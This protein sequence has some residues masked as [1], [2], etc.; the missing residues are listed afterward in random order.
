M[1]VLNYTQG[2][3][4]WLAWRQTRITATDAACIL[5]LNEYKSAHQLWQEKLGLVDPEPI[6]EAMLRGQELEPVAREIFIKE[7]GI[8]V[9]PRVVEHSEHWWMGASLDGLSTCGKIV[10]E[11]K[12]PGNRNHLFALAIGIRE[13]WEIQMQHQLF[14]T[15]ADIAYF[16][17][18]NPDFE[19][20]RKWA[21]YSMLPN[22]EFMAAMFDAEKYF[23]DVNICGMVDPDSINRLYTAKVGCA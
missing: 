11:I 7:T 1:K 19:E 16:I 14:V 22:A 6:N 21:T 13:Y 9:E 18:Y 5:G 3:A 20:G 17:S 2:S 12:C 10:L 8:F 4:D 23:Y 15:G